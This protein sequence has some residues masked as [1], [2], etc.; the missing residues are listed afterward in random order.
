VGG[1]AGA[2]QSGGGPYVGAGVVGAAD[3]LALRVAATL[4]ALIGADLTGDRV[5]AASRAEVAEQVGVDQ[6]KVAGVQGVLPEPAGLVVE[7]GVGFDDVVRDHLG[8]DLVPARVA[9]FGGG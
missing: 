5:D 7:E 2:G 6:G 4:P 1:A 3:L 9:V 8:R